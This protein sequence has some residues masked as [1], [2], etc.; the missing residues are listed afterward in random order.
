ME[1]RRNVYML[2]K[3]FEHKV[4]IVGKNGPNKQIVKKSFVVVKYNKYMGAIDKT[5]MLLSS[6]KCKTIK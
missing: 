3:E 6:V 1:D 4:V 5:D 2:S